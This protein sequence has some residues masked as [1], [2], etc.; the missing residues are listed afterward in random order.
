V[1]VRQISDRDVVWNLSERMLP[2][3]R[4]FHLGPWADLAYTFGG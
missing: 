3:Q 4:R 1:V 2:L